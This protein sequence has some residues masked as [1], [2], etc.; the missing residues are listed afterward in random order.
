MKNYIYTIFSAAAFIYGSFLCVHHKKCLYDPSQGSGLL[1]FTG[2]VIIMS[3]YAFINR[4]IKFTHPESTFSQ[5]LAL[6]I[7]I[8]ILIFMGSNLIVLKPFMQ[9]YPV[10]STENMAFFFGVY[11]VIF[12]VSFLHFLLQ[13]KTNKGD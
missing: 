4:L 13:I 3:N 8:F 10:F 1:L 9:E 11:L 2:F 6:S 12:G 5:R 7:C